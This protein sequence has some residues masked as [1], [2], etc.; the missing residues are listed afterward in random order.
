MHE[1]ELQYEM[2]LIK[3]QQRGFKITQEYRAYLYDLFNDRPTVLNNILKY[4]KV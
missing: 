4:Y 3:M 2:I 1:R